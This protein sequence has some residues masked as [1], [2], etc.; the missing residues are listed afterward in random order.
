MMI[1]QWC[2]LLAIVLVTNIGILFAQEGPV[3]MM[4]PP[5]GES[6]I[7]APDGIAAF[8]FELVSNHIVI[9]VEINGVSVRLI[10]DTGMPMEGIILS[11]TETVVK[12]NLPIMGKAPIKGAADGAVVM[13]DFAMGVDF[14]L[15]GVEFSDQMILVM[16]D[17]PLGEV[18]GVI[19]NSIFKHFVTSIDYDKMEITLTEPEKF[20]YTGKG[21]KIPLEIGMHPMTSG[22]G[23][24]ESGEMVPMPMTVDTGFQGA[25]GLSLS[26]EGNKFLPE[27][28]IEAFDAGLGER[29]PIKVGRTKGFHIGS[30]HFSNVLSS[31]SQKS[32]NP[33]K[34]GGVL[35]Q[36]I[37]KR[38]NII[39]DYSRKS[40]ILEPNAKFNEPFEFGNMAG[41]K[42]ERTDGGLLEIT[43][44]YP[45]SP[46]AEAGLKISD[47]LEKIDGQ[48]VEGLTQ[49]EVNSLLVQDG[50]E[51]MLGIKRN[52]ESISKRIVL[53][54]L[55]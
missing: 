40:M 27:K 12:L 26:P 34:N 8:P 45:D 16:R 17:N 19:G 55:I 9:P 10:L 33:N 53:H 13:S 38:F 28:C 6:K 39:F 32:R 7:I 51:V 3:R 46:V 41:F 24:M 4:A 21:E 18:D 1:K 50:R 54:R 5:P 22:V 43:H 35:G 23:E 44:I 42:S 31:F 20:N 15:P 36:E 25:I 49:D 48:T 2:F 52:G 47:L 14:K 37:L 30:Y 11:G 29:F